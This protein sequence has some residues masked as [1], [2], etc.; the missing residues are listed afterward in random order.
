MDRFALGFASVTNIPK[1]SVAYSS[2]IL[3]YLFANRLWLQVSKTAHLET[4]PR[5]KEDPGETSVS[6]QV[7]LK[8][9]QLHL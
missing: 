3:S 2:K 7:Q 8:L 1:I 4:Y 5:A 9:P 6:A